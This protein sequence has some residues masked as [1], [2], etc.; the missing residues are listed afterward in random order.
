MQRLRSFRP[1][2]R[3]PLELHELDQKLG[4]RDDRRRLD[5]RL[6]GADVE[7]RDLGDAVDQHLV[8][9]PAD[10]FP[11]DGI[12]QS[13]GITP[14]L[15]LEL[16]PL[17]AGERVRIGIIVEAAGIGIDLAIG[18]IDGRLARDP[19]ATDSLQHDVEAAALDLLR[20]DDPAEAAGT[21]RGTWDLDNT[22][23]AIDYTGALLIVLTGVLFPLVI[24]GTDPH[25]DT[26]RFLAW[27]LLLEAGMM[28]SFLSLDLFVF[29]I[30][31]AL[32]WSGFEQAGSSL[33]LVA[34]RFED[35]RV[36]VQHRARD[37]R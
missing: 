19:E 29:F 1:A 18:G 35:L 32:F 10:R 14:R 24:F 36:G 5:Q 2:W 13:I 33:N 31:S 4:A 12:A 23:L 6:L 26:K 20:T 17:D 34:D 7:R 9:E 3:Q 37:F 11:V 27:M 28:G 30:F 22:L 8:V 16:G 21:I 15:A 25:H